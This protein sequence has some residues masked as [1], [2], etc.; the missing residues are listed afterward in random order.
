MGPSSG[1]QVPLSA[2]NWSSN[3]R[4]LK[5]APPPTHSSFSRRT[6]WLKVSK[7][8]EWCK[9]IN[10]AALLCTSWLIQTRIM[11]HLK[12]L[13]RK[14]CM[15]VVAMF[16]RWEVCFHLAF[17]PVAAVSLEKHW[18]WPHCRGARELMEGSHVWLGR[19]WWTE[20]A[21]TIRRN[22]GIQ[23]GLGN[24]SLGSNPVGFF[25]SLMKGGPL[26]FKNHHKKLKCFTVTTFCA[27]EKLVIYFFLS[28]TVLQRNIKQLKAPHFYNLQYLV[29]KRPKR[30]PNNEMG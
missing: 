19:G 10:N 21:T 4:T 1:S 18:R 24:R 12:P 2:F 26:E 3:G 27:G 11:L 15:A 28:V 9:K 6:P 13:S 22:A 29:K 5:N 17:R 30:G 16:F 25:P 14:L 7:V 20:E 8:V 23:E